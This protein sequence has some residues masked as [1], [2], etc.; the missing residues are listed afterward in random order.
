MQNEFDK[1]VSLKF[2]SDFFKEE[3]RCDYKITEKAKKI[4]AIQLDLLHQLD[5][6][7]KQYG[8][9]YFVYCGTLLGAVRHKGFIP[10]DD[11]IDVAMSREDF[12]KFIKVAPASFKHP[13]FLQTALTDKR[14]FLAYA[15]LRNSLTTGLIL[16]QPSSEYNQGIYI[17]IFVLDGYVE[18]DKELKKYL[19]KKSNL[20]YLLNAYQMNDLDPNNRTKNLLKKVLHYTFCKIVPLKI[21]Y[22]W[23]NKNLSYYNN[24]TERL[25]IMTHP[26]KLFR[27]YWCLK[28]EIENV[29]YMPFE[30]LMIPVPA[31][32][33]EVLTHMYGD[34]MKFPPIEKRGVWHEGILEFDPDLSYKQYIENRNR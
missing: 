30:S 28:D 22:G 32:Y 19:Q 29:V 16:S 8:I 14:Y 34:Y 18:D 13:Y 24:K 23:Y 12:N 27:N 3:V 20:N 5:E 2:E 1:K 9:K 17:D 33:K 25:S 11:D 6:V 26:P 21:V 10:W 4:M 31:K 15:R 7:C